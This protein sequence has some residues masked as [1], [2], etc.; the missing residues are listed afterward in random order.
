MVMQS[1][2][3]IQR[4]K[5]IQSCAFE[6]GIIVRMEGETVL[7]SD[8][9]MDG[10]WDDVISTIM[11]DEITQITFGDNYSKLFYKYIEK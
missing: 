9:G 1:R 5:Q 4:E 8:I 2:L 10:E 11:L 7:F 3:Q 6:L